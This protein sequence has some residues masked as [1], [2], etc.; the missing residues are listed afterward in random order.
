MQS[1][2]P[3]SVWASFRKMMGPLDVIVLT[4]SVDRTTIRT[5]QR[6]RQKWHL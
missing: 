4:T 2:S 1:I 3:E 6:A 5:E